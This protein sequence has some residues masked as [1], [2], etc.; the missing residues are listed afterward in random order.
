MNDAP[1]LIDINNKVATITINNPKAMNALD[2]KMLLAIEETFEGLLCND[3]V[4]V[5]VITGAGDRA[6]V[7]GGDIADI[8]SRYGLQ[9]YLEFGE[10]IHRVFRKIESSDKPTI[11]SINGWALGGGVELLLTTDIRLCS[12]TAKLGV[13]E[14]NLG[15]FPGAGGATRLMKQ[16]SPC[17]AKELMFTGDQITAAEALRIGLVNRVVPLAQLA[18]ETQKIAAQIAS[19]SPLV[20]KL[21]KRNLLHG[22]DMTL[23][24]AL[25]YEQAM[26]GL[27]M[28][29]ADSHEGTSAFLE[30]RK[31]EFKGQ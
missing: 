2:I 21:L 24:S 12:E 1:V 11:S 13:P 25:H 18:E 9:H 28:D 10:I 5:I 3:N 8:N 6:F 20:L 22:Q 29:T 16:L 17:I 4:N 27:V 26:I 23:A 14:I 19:K 30:K 7:A 31:A 15:V